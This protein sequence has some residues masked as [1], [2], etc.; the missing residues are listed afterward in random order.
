MPNFFR[1]LFNPFFSTKS[2]AGFLGFANTVS[3]NRRSFHDSREFMWDII[4]ECDDYGSSLISKVL[5]T[6]ITSIAGNGVSVSC[7]DTNL[8]NKVDIFLKKNNLSGIDIT[9][10]IRLSEVEGLIAFNITKKNIDTGIPKVQVLCYRLNGLHVSGEYDKYSVTVHDGKQEIKLNTDNV[11]LIQV[12]GVKGCYETTPTVPMRVLMECESFDRCLE[13]IRHNN[14]LHGISFP[15]METKTP[16]DASNI[17]SLL[18]SDTSFKWGSG[19]LLVA[20]AKVDFPSPRADVINSLTKELET[21]IRMVSTHTGIPV[22]LLGFP[23]LYSQKGGIHEVRNSLQASTLREKK[24]WESA[25]HKLLVKVFKVDDD[26]IQVSLPMTS[27]ADLEN[28]RDIYLPLMDAGLISKEY[29]AGKVP[30]IDYAKEKSIIETEQKR[31]RIDAVK[32][33]MTALDGDADEPAG[34]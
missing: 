19:D 28:I 4:T 25:L 33:T 24:I 23:D 12:G 29:V 5:E 14:H 32:D 10:A 6:R 21:L 27:V 18:G 34:E 8:Q 22:Y 11:I 16:D 13:D 26:A 1:N 3:K 20:P 30:S 9:D 17:L 15:F 2:R 7:T 31:E